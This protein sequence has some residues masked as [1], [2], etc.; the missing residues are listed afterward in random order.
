MDVAL[1]H[2]AYV[3]NRSS[4]DRNQQRTPLEVQSGDTPDISALLMYAFYEKV[5]YYDP[6]QRFP[7]TKEATGWFVGV[8]EN[9]GDA[10]CY[11]I[12]AEDNKTILHRSVVRPARDESRPNHRLYNLPIGATGIDT[13]DTAQR[14]SIWRDEP[15]HYDAALIEPVQLNGPAQQTEQEPDDPDGNM[16]N[17][18]TQWDSDVNSED[19]SARHLIDDINTD[20]VVH[21]LPTVTAEAGEAPQ[22]SHPDPNALIGKLFAID[23][24]GT[25]QTGTVTDVNHDGTETMIDLRMK[26]DGA[27]T[28]LVYSRFLDALAEDVHPFHGIYGHRPVNKAKGS[29][30]VFILWGTGETTWEPLSSIWNA[31]KLTVAQYARENGLL[32]TKGWRRTKSVRGDTA[33][34][35]QLVRLF[36]ASSASWDGPKYKF[37]V[38]VPRNTKEAYRID[39]ENGDTKWA[40]AIEKELKQIDDYNT[41]RVVGDSEAID[42]TYKQIP[43]HMIYDV[44]FDLRR[45]ARLVAGGNHTEPPKEDIYSGV[46]GMETIRLGFA[47]A[48]M[49]NLSVCAADVGNAFLYGTTKEK[50]YIRAGPEFG[51]LRRGKRLIIVKSLYGLRSSSARYHE[52]FADTMLHLGYRPSQADPNLWWIDRGGGVL[53]VCGDLCGRPSCVCSTTHGPHQNPT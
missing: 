46:V 18:F 1:E 19:T 33:R 11:K 21:P 5:Y 36:K 13:E 24:D 42:S 41:F 43:Y 53:R 28:R 15:V 3:W 14:R 7:N 16:E 20:T 37:G 47:L 6:Q 35:A 29:W 51:K 39:R 22:T 50:V 45:K 44:K 49:N 27:T 31:D 26:A 8:A 40:D 2:A 38:Q 32:D 10:L 30:E 25:I 9:I 17:G 52:A 4:S 34:L 23:H 48:A 12:L